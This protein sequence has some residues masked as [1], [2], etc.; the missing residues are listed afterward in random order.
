MPACLSRVSFVS[1]LRSKSVLLLAHENADLD[2]ICS[3]AIM[4]RFLRKNK[5]FSVIGIPSHINDAA[6]EF[7]KEQA[8][9]FVLSPDLDG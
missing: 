9:S 7:C 1:F 4:Q 2:A 3:A 5:I 6:K 8:V